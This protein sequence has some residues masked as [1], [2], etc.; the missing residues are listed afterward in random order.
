MVA[1]FISGIFFVKNHV[2]ARWVVGCMVTGMIF[3]VIAEKAFGVP[4]YSG[5][6][7]LV[8]VVF[9]SPALYHLLTKRP[10]LGQSSTFT[11]WSGVI[12]FVICF[13]FIFDI[14]DAVIYLDHAL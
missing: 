8:H 7:A 10:F 1:T 9:W 13:S 12:T 11:I 2:T 4:N 6:I 14:R 3:G 5:F